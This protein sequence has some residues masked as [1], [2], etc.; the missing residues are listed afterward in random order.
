MIL[1]E[2]RQLIIALEKSVAS[3]ETEKVSLLKRDTELLT[4]VG[5]K[6]ALGVLRGKICCT[7]SKQFS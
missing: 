6:R 5:G 2:M 7:A 3:L 4:K 1:N